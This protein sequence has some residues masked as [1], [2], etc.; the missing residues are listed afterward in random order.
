MDLFG[1]EPQDVQPEPFADSDVLVDAAHG[2]AVGDGLVPAREMSFCLGHQS[3]ED[4]LL[5]SFN[6]DRMPHG[7]IF[8]GIKGI[9][10]ATMAYRLAR[11]MLKHGGNDS[12]QESMFGDAAPVKVQSLD[13]A[14]DD[15]VFR[16]VISGGHADFMSIERAYD[17]AKNKYATGV[18]VDDIRRVPSFLRMTASD[19]GWRVVIIDDA[20]MMN[21][22]AQNAL[23]KILEEPPKNALLILVAHRLGALIPTIRSRAQ[24][25]NFHPLSQDNIEVLL[26]QSG[27]AARDLQTLCALAEGSIGQAMNYAQD[28]G[29]ESLQQIVDLLEACPNWDWKTIHALADNMAG[30]GQV[31]SYDIF[32]HLLCWLFSQLV[33]AKARGRDLPSGLVDQPSI[34]R[35]LQNSSLEKLMKICDNLHSHFAKVSATNLDKKQ[36]ILRAFELISV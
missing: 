29:L 28:G 25:L 30:A 9:G 13:V 22:S 17:A 27:Y 15:P 7:L 24:V 6:A 36:G 19:G 5:E 8:S 23:L 4:K 14:P 33:V 16:R 26:R 32:G 20:D 34:H 1:E 31:E 10:K 11:F 35:L 3:V 21:R 2:V 18:A 12:V